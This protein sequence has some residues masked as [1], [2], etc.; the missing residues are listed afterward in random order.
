[1]SDITEAAVKWRD[2]IRWQETRGKKGRRRK[3]GGAESE[4]K[5]RE[6]R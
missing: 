1:M 3:Q 2:G 5:E 4:G 6:M